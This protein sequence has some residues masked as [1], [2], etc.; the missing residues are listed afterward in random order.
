MARKAARFVVPLERD[1]DLRHGLQDDRRRPFADSAVMTQDK[2]SSLVGTSPGDEQRAEDQVAGHRRRTP[3]TLTQLLRV[4]GEGLRPVELAERGRSERGI[5][6]HESRPRL[7]TA[8]DAFAGGLEQVA[9]LA[10]PTLKQLDLTSEVVNPARQ[11]VVGCQRERHRQQLTRCFSRSGELRALCGF[12]Q[13]LRRAVR[14]STVSR[15]ERS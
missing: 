7:V 5:G 1:E 14:D 4:A 11:A 3:G 13:S 15:A 12:D 8:R 2:L 6:E 9:R 10:E